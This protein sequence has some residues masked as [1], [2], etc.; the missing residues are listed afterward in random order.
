[1]RSAG[2][3][4]LLVLFPAVL[5]FFGCQP[6]PLSE[7]AAPRNDRAY[8]AAIN[9]DA[10]A[11]RT[12]S[13]FESVTISNRANQ[14]F[15]SHAV[16]S[17]PAD[18]SDGQ[19]HRTHRLAPGGVLEGSNAAF[20]LLAYG[21]G[22]PQVVVPNTGG[23]IPLEFF[24][25]DGRPMARSEQAAAG[26]KPWHKEV[27][28]SGRTH[29][30]LLAFF[31]ETNRPPGGIRP[32]ALFDARTKAQLTS[33]ASWQEVSDRSPGK[34]QVEPRAW[35]ATPLELVVDVELDGKFVR[36]VEP[37][38][39]TRQVLPGGEVFFA[40]IW[41][42]DANSTSSSEEGKR[43]A[44]TIGLSMSDSG[45]KSSA[46]FVTDP[47]GFSV[48]IAL[49]DERG[50]VIEGHSGMTSENIKAVGVATNAEAVKRIRF[51]VFTNHHRVVIPLPPLAGLPPENQNVR[52]LFDVRIPRAEI[53]NEYDFRSFIGHV[54][55]ME[56][57]YSQTNVFPTGYFPRVFT[58]VTPAELLQLHGHLLGSERMF[59]VDRDKLEIRVEP[60]AWRKLWL[61][62]KA[63]LRLK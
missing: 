57:K 46:I 42:G 35:H 59:V 9:P 63:K 51:T 18:G 8:R 23:R 1:M 26:L 38:P 7:P 29:P 21:V 34:I 39:N 5:V 24:H 12:G 58:N 16:S 40:G 48:Q 11:K 33:G 55:Q 52:D 10:P 44:M 43:R 36:E 4:W 47:L 56:F 14:V 41:D 50:R 15:I 27:W 54:T 2:S 49:L 45:E 32:I 28:V 3:R 60:P 22:H 19:S 62:T 6:A 17:N 30:Q 20:R 31:G 53:R 37:T 25:P 61:W 13:V